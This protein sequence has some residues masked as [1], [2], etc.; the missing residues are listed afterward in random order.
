MNSSPC[1]ETLE[2]LTHLWT[3]HC[4]VLDMT[5]GVC[6]LLALPCFHYASYTAV[7]I[8]NESQ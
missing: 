2:T 3:V 5:L 1:G 6:V 4:M 8:L 7:D